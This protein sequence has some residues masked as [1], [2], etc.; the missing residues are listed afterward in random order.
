MVVDTSGNGEQVAQKR[1]ELRLFFHSV[2][3][4]ELQGI[5]DSL[6]DITQYL[7][8]TAPRSPRVNFDLHQNENFSPLSD[9]IL[10]EMETIGQ[11]LFQYEKEYAYEITQ[12]WMSCLKPGQSHHPHT[13]HNT[14]WSGVF[15]LNGEENEFPSINFENPFYRHFV[16]SYKKL[17]EYNCNNWQVPTKKD[18]LVIFP[19]YLN[20]WVNENNTDTNRI[21]V[22]FNIILRGRYEAQSSLQ[23]VEI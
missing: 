17:N 12:M 4:A 6:G 10:R 21:S 23:S 1:Q 16:L 5:T 20:H 14:L 18:K 9:A 19:S 8:L 15:Y 22:A 11:D 7:R 3:T 2:F 13:H